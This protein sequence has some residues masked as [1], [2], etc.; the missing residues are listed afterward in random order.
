MTQK[1]RRHERATARSPSDSKRRKILGI[2]AAIFIV[3]GLAWLAL[4]HFV[5]ALRERTDDAYVAGYQVEHLLA[6]RRAP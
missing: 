5:L 1:K 2:I 4:S 3:I 6:G